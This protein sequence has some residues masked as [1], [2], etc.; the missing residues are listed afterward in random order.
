VNGRQNDICLKEIGLRVQ[1]LLTVVDLII[2]VKWGIARAFNELK[3]IHFDN[4]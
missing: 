4:K 2:N 1:H 3:N